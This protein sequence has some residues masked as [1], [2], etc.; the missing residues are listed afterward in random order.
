MVEYTNLVETDFLLV[1]NDIVVKALLRRGM[2]HEKLDKLVQAKKDY[3][4]VKMIDPSNL[5]AS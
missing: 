4:K 5:N 1:E 2:A 3:K